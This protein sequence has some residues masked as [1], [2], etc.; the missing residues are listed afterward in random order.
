MRKRNEVHSNRAQLKG[1]RN[2]LLYYLGFILREESGP[3]IH[4]DRGDAIGD[5]SWFML[6]F[7][8][9]K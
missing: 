2:K 6:L 5:M 9:K 4:E 7:E 1:Q 3:K 8:S